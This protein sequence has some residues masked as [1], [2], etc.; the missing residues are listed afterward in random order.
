MGEQGATE[1]T[2][3][4]PDGYVDTLN[5]L[6]AAGEIT[7]DQY[8]T[9][10]DEYEQWQEEQRTA[11]ERKYSVGTT[12]LSADVAQSKSN[13]NT[14][15]ENSQG[16][17]SYSSVSLADD[18]AP[19]TY[20]FLTSQPDMNVVGL[21]K[22]SA[23]R[24]DSG[25]ID[26]AK[27]VV[28][29]LKN[30]LSVGTKRDGKI[31]VE[32]QYSG[33]LLRIDV[34]A[35][36]HGLN[37]KS[38]RLI[39]NARLGSRIGDIVRNAIPIN[40][41]HD[42]SVNAEGT[43]AMAAYATDEVGREIVAIVTVEQNSGNVVG[44]DAFDVTHAVSGRQKRSEQ[45]DTESQGVNPIKLTSKIRIADLIE[46]VNSTYR[47][48][49]SE[50]VLNAIGE[51]RPVGGHYSDRVKFSLSDDDGRSQEHDTGT[52]NKKDVARDLQAILQRGGSV[53]EL[54]Q[55]VAQLERTG[56]KAEQSGRSAEQKRGE[57]EQ[58]LEKAK[59]RGVSVEQYLQENAE[60]YES[61]GRWNADAR[62]ALE[63]EK[64]G[65]GRKYSV[66]EG[67]ETATA[68]EK[69]AQIYMLTAHLPRIN[70]IRDDQMV[71]LA[72][73]FGVKY[74]KDFLNL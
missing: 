32:N 21:P 28:E 62:E 45:A 48:I 70:T 26:T 13:E 52:V 47:S 6:L 66:S 22:L 65:S 8:D 33:R 36:R 25:K 23:I 64:K 63:L 30:A 41:L 3:E 56:G 59:R 51:K 58:I 24:N 73:F 29:G 72:E 20:S 27:V 34:S 61:D 9:A 35:I 68:E 71:E 57:A 50:D 11:G 42:A 60:L 31:Y 55:Y 19:Y 1:S 74:R 44:V 18:P 39:T 46:N 53:S 14:L 2:A 40:A 37:G 17:S 12:E 67:T 54:R 16:K 5:A 4:N 15:S 69:A 49:L 7:D 43:Y 38:N 10:M